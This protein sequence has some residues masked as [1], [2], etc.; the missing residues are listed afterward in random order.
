MAALKCFLLSTFLCAALLAG[1]DATRQRFCGKS[2][3]RRVSQMCHE[4]SCPEGIDMS[5]L[6]GDIDPELGFQ[7]TQEVLETHN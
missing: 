1:S 2:L 3:M 7:G 4:H 5:W 6:M